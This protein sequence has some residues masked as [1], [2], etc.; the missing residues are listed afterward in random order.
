MQGT[1]DFLDALA[2]QYGGASDYA[3]AKRLGV[4]KQSISNYRSGIRYIGD[5]LAIRIAAELELDPAYVLAC[6]NA[7]RER[8][9]TVSRVW[10]ELARRL[11]AVV[12]ALGAIGAAG[13]GRSGSHNANSGAFQTTDCTLRGKRQRRPATRGRHGA[14]ALLPLFPPLLP[15]ADGSTRDLGGPPTA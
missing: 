15:S 12:L 11:A 3:L 2:R 4:S 10:Q 13:D 14:A 6:V 1:R 7:E 8:E 5:E 9:P